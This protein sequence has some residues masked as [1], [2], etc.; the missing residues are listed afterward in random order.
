MNTLSSRW[1]I[2]I[3][4]TINWTCPWCKRLNMTNMEGNPLKSVAYSDLEDTCTSCQKP[5]SVTPQLK[6]ELNQ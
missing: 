2:K 1:P 4:I 3:D 5:V 6:D